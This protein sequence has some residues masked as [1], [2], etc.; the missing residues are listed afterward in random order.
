ML[1][2]V[3]WGGEMA[4]L[5]QT[6]GA[7][8]A[9]AD[10]GTRDNAERLASAIGVDLPGGDDAVFERASRLIAMFEGDQH[11]GVKALI[12]GLWLQVRKPA[13]TRSAEST[14]KMM[15]A[16]LTIN[17]EDHADE[18]MLFGDYNLRDPNTYKD[19]ALEKIA[20]RVTRKPGLLP[21]GMPYAI[22]R[23]G[24]L[25]G[26]YPELV[27]AE[28]EADRVEAEKATKAAATKDKKTANAASALLEMTLPPGYK[29]A[30][31]ESKKQYTVSGKFDEDLNTRLRRAGG[32]WNGVSKGNR[33]LWEVPE[34]KAS[35]LKTVLSNW[36]EAN[37][38]AIAAATDKAKRDE[39]ARL[40]A[41]R[42]ADAALQAIRDEASKDPIKTGQYGKVSV[43]WNGKEYRVGFPYSPRWVD[44]IKGFGGH[45]YDPVL[46]T[47]AMNPEDKEHL[48]NFI[49][50]IGRD[51]AA[52]EEAKQVSARESAKNDADNGVVLRKE[53][54]Y[55]YPKTN[56]NGKLI[57]EDGKVYEVIETG[58]ASKV[59]GED[60]SSLG[61]PIGHDEDM[62]VR[63][64][65]LR[66]DN[67]AHAQQMLQ[68]DADNK[69]ADEARRLAH[70]ERN[71]IAD[72]IK[73]AGEL[74]PAGSVA[75]GQE[76]GS[77]RSIYGGGDWFVIGPEYIW[78][79]MNNSMDGDNWAAS[80]L[81]GAIGWRVP[82][83]REL[84]D[85]IMA[86]A[87]V[88]DDPEQIGLHP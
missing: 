16:L 74:P 30:Y 43:R 29:V 46:K 23:A 37:G 88:K 50:S 4:E 25:S 19:P 34:G 1:L 5:K 48:Q 45:G 44:R 13:N 86:M 10:K 21:E 40:E 14:N 75:E 57:I 72:E 63:T 68:E 47:W 31:E 35:T 12:D 2:N 6:I 9:L 76:V 24:I 39:E 32:A 3:K 70:I 69:A 41:K 60:V 71:R 66:P 83:S 49:D 20:Q 84:S 79:V 87:G 15:D 17:R 22:F 85:R 42:Q 11:P 52:E 82:Y 59:Y 67:S 73:K 8:I 36:A 7:V 62:W 26:Q 27:Y 53:W 38:V 65:K 28:L 77:T 64:L 54:L 58:S 81:N 78:Y 55:S 51:V 61:G 18:P 56:A 80:N 33:R